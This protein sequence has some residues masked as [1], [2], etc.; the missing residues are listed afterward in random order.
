MGLWDREL[1]ELLP[2][3]M[4]VMAS[5][6]AGFDWVDTGVLAEFGMCMIL[7]AARSPDRHDRRC[8]ALDARADRREMAPT[9]KTSE[10]WAYPFFLAEN[11]AWLM[12]ARH[13]YRYPVLQWRPCLH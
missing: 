11:C 6:G 9:P 12:H 2:T 1:I 4:R 13:G 5:A 8:K 3:S 10:T 7:T